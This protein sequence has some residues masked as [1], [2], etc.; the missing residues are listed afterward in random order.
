MWRL[1]VKSPICDKEILCY[2]EAKSIAELV[3]QYESK[4]NN[5]FIN[6]Y[7]LDNIKRGRCE[8]SF[9]FISLERF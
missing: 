5:N 2:L 9:P 7:K 3:K 8:K 1:I 6:Y 4:Y